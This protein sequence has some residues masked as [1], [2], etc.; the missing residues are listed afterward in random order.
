MAAAMRTV[1]RKLA[2]SR[3]ARRLGVGTVIIGA[4][5]LPCSSGAETVTYDLTGR[6]TSAHYKFVLDIAKCGEA[7]CGIKINVD[8]S[9]GALALRLRHVAKAGDT[10]M[11][12]GRLDL[13]PDIKPYEVSIS[14]LNANNASPVEVQMLGDPNEAP[15]FLTRT[16]PFYDRL[17]RNGDAQCKP[18]PKTS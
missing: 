2:D 1:R 15:S 9:C 18:E 13:Q 7:W 5:I 3:L 16:I 11:L 12:V 10:V 4:L 14:F 17:A 6:W 8:Q